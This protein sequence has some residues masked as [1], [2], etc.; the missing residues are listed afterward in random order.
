MFPEAMEPSTDTVS[1]GRV[2]IGDLE[3]GVPSQLLEPE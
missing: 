3:L 2:K 1:G